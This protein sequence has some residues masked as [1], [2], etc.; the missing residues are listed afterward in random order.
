MSTGL[1]SMQFKAAY[2]TPLLK[3]EDQAHPKRN[4]IGPFKPRG[5]VKDFRTTC[6]SSVFF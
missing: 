1:F 3:K 6:C 4:L 2:I 5:L